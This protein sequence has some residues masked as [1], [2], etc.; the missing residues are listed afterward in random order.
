[1]KTRPILPIGAGYIGSALERR[2]DKTTL[3]F[4]IVQSVRGETLQDHYR[5]NQRTN[6]HTAGQDTDYHKGP[7]RW[8]PIVTLKE[9]IARLWQTLVGQP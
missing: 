4:E 7:L 2:L 5:S 3:P 8:M 6:V 1:M 9:G